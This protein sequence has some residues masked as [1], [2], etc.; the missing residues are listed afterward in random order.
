M[1]A[2][3][4]AA[5]KSSRFYPYS[6]LPHK[7]CFKVLGKTILEHTLLSIKKAGINDVIIVVGP[8]DFIKEEINKKN[9]ELNITYIV[10][11]SPL[12]MGDALLRVRE[13]IKG[14]F[15]L[16]NS[17][18]LNFHEFKDLMVDKKTHSEE[19]VLLAK[20][21]TNPE[22][23]GVLNFVGE[24]VVGV[25]EKPKK[26]EE[27]SNLKVIGIYLFPLSFLNTLRD[28]NLE[29]YSLEQAISNFAIKS[30]VTYIETDNTDVSLKHAWDI[31]DITNYLL[32]DIKR[33]ISVD[34]DIKASAIIDGNVIIEDG[35]K[36]LEGA[37][38]KGP[39][40][41]GKNV[42]IGNNALI[43]SSAVIE[44]NCLIG[45]FS[46][47]KNS[48]FFNNSKIHA[49]LIED[50]IIGENCRIGAFFCTANRR[51]DKEEIKFVT[52]NGLVN[53]TKTFMGAVIGNNVTVGARCLTMPGII[54]GNNVTIGPSTTLIKNVPDNTKIYAD[55]SNN[56]TEINK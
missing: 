24:K 42:L 33:D 27:P 2:V 5:G 25:V 45:A 23:F 12:G 34:A 36:V 7:S 15:F 11:P 21:V 39:C 41:I 38:I 17:E 14:D 13:I 29:E 50:S 20:K 48:V 16:L 8:G 40:Y 53:S 22:L 3:I 43:R 19:I 30:E 52:N 4:L 9:L 31:L 56:I 18:K 37:V 28:S 47:V 51:L 6:N 55:I 26:G 44:E 46:E 1:Q 35:V 54:I 49:G 10:Q 32:K